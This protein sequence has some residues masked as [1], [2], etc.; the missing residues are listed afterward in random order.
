MTINENSAVLSLNG[1]EVKIEFLHHW[2]FIA[3]ENLSDS[4]VKISRSENIEGRTDG[5]IIIPAGGSVNYSVIGGHL[6]LIGTGTVNVMGTSSS[7]NPFKVAGKGGGGGSGTTDYEALSNKPSIEGVTL[8]G[9]K[10]W[11]ELGLN[12]GG[13]KLIGTY[14]N[15]VVGDNN[16][17]LN[18]ITFGYDTSYLLKATYNFIKDLSNGN[19][20][21]E[22]I[23]TKTTL[24]Y[25]RTGSEIHDTSD[26]LSP[27][28]CIWDNMIDIYDADEEAGSTVPK[29]VIGYFARYNN[30]PTCKVKITTASYYHIEDLVIEVY[31]IDSLKNI[32]EFIKKLEASGTTNYNDLQNKPTLNGVPIEGNKSS[33]DYG[34]E[35]PDVS[36][37]VSNPN[38]EPILSGS[39]EAA[40]TPS[41]NGISVTLKTGIL[42]SFEKAQTNFNINLVDLN[43]AGLV[44]PTDKTIIDS[45][46]PAETS[47][48][49]DATDEKIPTSKAVQLY[50]LTKLI[51]MG[52]KPEIVPELPETGQS[53]I[54]YLVPRINGI[55]GDN[56]HDE[57]LWVNNRFELLASTGI[58]LSDYA[59]IESL[60]SH[61]NDKN[62]P[63]E[64]KPEQIEKTAIIIYDGKTVAEFKNELLNWWDSACGTLSIY[65]F[66][67]GTVPWWLENFNNDEEIIPAGATYTIIPI[68]DYAPD[69]RHATFL[70]SAA[71]NSDKSNEILKL[72]LFNSKFVYLN[73][74]VD[75][76]NKEPNV[77][78][79]LAIPVQC[80]GR[81]I[82]ELKNVILNWYK[83]NISNKTNTP[84]ILSGDINQ[85]ITHWSEPTFVLSGGSNISVSVAVPYVD[86]N[87]G[88][89]KIACYYQGGYEF[90][91]RIYN[92]NLDIPIKVSPLGYTKITSD[93]D[94][95]TITDFGFYIVSSSTLL[96]SEKN[97]PNGVYGY[98]TLF[99]MS[100]PMLTGD[101]YQL[102][103]SFNHE[104]YYRSHSSNIFGNWIR[105][106]NTDYG[107]GISNSNLDWNSITKSG[108]YTIE[109]DGLIT[110]N[111][112][113]PLGVIGQG[114]L[115]VVNTGLG[116]AN[117]ACIRQIYETGSQGTYTRYKWTIDGAWTP[118]YKYQCQEYSP[119]QSESEEV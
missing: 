48:P 85:I 102:Y 40:S 70:F 46:L 34:I 10:T 116:S 73:R 58:D 51:S 32:P 26:I 13:L 43:N 2:S 74:L 117:P 22:S 57:Y 66:S 86:K 87:Y 35:I 94:W 106:D 77:W 11:E 90:L 71:S 79:H 7:E 89:L 69:K 38:E 101:K 56:I 88:I 110:A 92:D 72:E 97:A 33:S 119:T 12:E 44:S 96:T 17:E 62:N 54:L 24:I 50:V 41:M 61:I 23:Q 42:N 93:I 95:N 5:V 20:S 115:T 27:K 6:Y 31:D 80:N 4:D 29:V 108:R 18:P 76:S 39:I 19:Y 25:I 114:L 49:D 30:V 45:V 28:S 81:T 60:N 14:D 68:A 21:K 82:Q 65:R 107:Y 111:S 83:N 47:I 36:D 55:T 53:N 113:G 112:H 118:W 84:C 91:C 16:Y 100:A 78:S 1:T 75:L 67:G 99:V 103:I 9:N 3:V 63:H 37:M 64:V 59:T 98:G 52:F 104:I 8:S 105:L 15:F 109:Y